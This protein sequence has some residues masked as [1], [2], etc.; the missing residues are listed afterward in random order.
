MTNTKIYLDTVPEKSR[1]FGLGMVFH[2]NEKKTFSVQIDH[3]SAT[4]GIRSLGGR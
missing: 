1:P 3:V 2:F 4:S